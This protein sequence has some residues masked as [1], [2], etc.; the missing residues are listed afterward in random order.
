[1]KAVIIAPSP[2]HTHL[3]SGILNFLSYFYNSRPNSISSVFSNSLL[4]NDTDFSPCQYP[5]KH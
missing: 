1:M 3:P 5:P 2:L 4:K